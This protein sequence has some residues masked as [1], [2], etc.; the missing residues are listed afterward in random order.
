[1]TFGW[2]HTADYKKKQRLLELV[3]AEK[4]REKQKE[5]IS[6]EE[7]ELENKQRQKIIEETQQSLNFDTEQYKDIHQGL[8]LSETLYERD[9]NE[10]IRK[11]KERAI[12]LLSLIHI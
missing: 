8:K 6:K 3:K 2:T 4:E 1:M 9:K 12:K 5:E 10:E 7:L 11:E